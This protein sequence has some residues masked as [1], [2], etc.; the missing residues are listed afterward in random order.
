MQRIQRNFLSQFVMTF[1]NSYTELE[2]HNVDENEMGIKMIIEY[3]CDSI[4]IEYSL[5]TRVRET[6]STSII[7]SSDPT[8]LKEL[9][10]RV[11]YS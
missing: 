10:G 11:M 2:V 3:L 1:N 5:S 7:I 9:Y 6:K 8:S 4:G